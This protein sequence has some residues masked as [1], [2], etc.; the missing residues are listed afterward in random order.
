M[1]G[2]Q[3]FLKKCMILSNLKMKPK[4]RNSITK[5]VKLDRHLYDSVND[6]WCWDEIKSK[7]DEIRCKSGLGDEE[8]LNGDGWRF[9]TKVR[10]IT[11]GKGSRNRRGTTPYF[12]GLRAVIPGVERRRGRG[13]GDTKG[14]GEAFITLYIYNIRE[15]RIDWRSCALVPQ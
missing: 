5:L 6:F 1:R 10:S 9:A 7:I 2:Q 11:E 4:S 13:G 14:W 8:E 3:K 12:R 15:N